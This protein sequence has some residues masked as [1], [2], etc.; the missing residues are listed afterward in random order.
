M[1]AYPNISPTKI[2]VEFS[3]YNRTNEEFDTSDYLTKPI[4]TIGLG[5]SLSLTYNPITDVEILALRNFYNFTQRR[6]RFTLPLQISDCL[7]NDVIEIL[8]KAKATWWVID[9]QWEIN[10]IFINDACSLYSL[11]L[12]IKSV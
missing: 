6:K 5:L 7:P 12:R 3:Q 8:T 9:S 2:N 1:V 11:T 10:P 4:A